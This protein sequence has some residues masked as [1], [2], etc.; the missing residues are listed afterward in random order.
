MSSGVSHLFSVHLCVW[1]PLAVICFCKMDYVVNICLVD[2]IYI[3][4][5]DFDSS[6]VFEI[7]VT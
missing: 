1:K 2:T 5:E 4:V 7:L 6:K 3:H